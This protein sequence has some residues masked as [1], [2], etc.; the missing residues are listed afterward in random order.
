MTS[1]AASAARG[2]PTNHNATKH[3]PSVQ[4]NDANR[5]VACGNHLGRI[6]REHCS[7]SLIARALSGTYAASKENGVHT[8]STVCA[9]QGGYP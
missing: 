8:A 4:R 6:R 7:C 5:V 2:Q 3:A 1:H 9:R